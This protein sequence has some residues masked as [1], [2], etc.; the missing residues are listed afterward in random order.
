MTSPR[1]GATGGPWQWHGRS[2][3][4]SRDRP[5]DELRL[6]YNV[7]LG[8]W[9][10]SM[11]LSTVGG[12][13]ACRSAGQFSTRYGKI[14]DMVVGMEVALADGRVVGT[15][16]GG[17]RGAVGPDLNQV[18]VGSEGTLGVITSADLIV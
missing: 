5:E 17:P 9:P 18:F 6:T 13:L 3:A 7:T 10:Q 8:H 15:G 14:E 1:P 4:R 12:W 2:M 11:N 16:T